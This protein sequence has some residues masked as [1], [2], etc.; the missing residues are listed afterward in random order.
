MDSRQIA[1]VI[2]I[3]NRYIRVLQTELNID[4]VYLY[5]SY[6]KGLH[7]EDSDIDI[8]IVSNSFSDDLYENTCKLMELRRKVDMRIE[9]HPF[10][11]DDFDLSNPFIREIVNTG[12]EI[13]LP[14]AG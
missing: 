9:P 7:G 10:R 4:I 5:G 1:E 2:E 11:L 8:A 12:I 3:V 14:I 6:A 13:Q